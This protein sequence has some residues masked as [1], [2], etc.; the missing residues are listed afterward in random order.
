MT[1][2]WTA[3]TDRFVPEES[4]AES[5]RAERSQDAMRAAAARAGSASEQQLRTRTDTA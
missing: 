5:H 4:T 2:T 1:Q 3:F